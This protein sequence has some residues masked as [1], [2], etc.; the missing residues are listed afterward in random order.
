[1]TRLN[2]ETAVYFRLLFYSELP[3]SPLR[4]PK[5]E[6][7]QTEHVAAAI[8]ELL[9]LIDAVQYRFDERASAA[10]FAAIDPE[11]VR[12]FDAALVAIGCD[13]QRRLLA[14]LQRKLV[15]E[16]SAL[17]PVERVDATARRLARDEAP[18]VRAWFLVDTA[19]LQ[20]RLTGFLE[21]RQQL[22]ELPPYEAPAWDFRERRAPVTSWRSDAGTGG[23]NLFLL[24]AD[25]ALNASI[26]AWLRSCESTTHYHAKNRTRVSN[27]AEVLAAE[28]QRAWGTLATSLVGEPRAGRP[29]PDYFGEYGIFSN[30]QPS[31]ALDR[32]ASDFRWS[33]FRW[34]R[35]D[36]QNVLAF[37]SDDDAV[38]DRFE[39]LADDLGASSL[40]SFRRFD[41][42]EGIAC[43]LWFDERDDDGNAVLVA[44]EHDGCPPWLVLA[45]RDSEWHWWRRTTLQLQ[46]QLWH[47]TFHFGSPELVLGYRD[48]DSAAWRE[49]WSHLSHDSN[50]AVAAVSGLVG[51]NA[52]RERL[53]KVKTL[54]SADDLRYLAGDDGWCYAHDWGSG[55]DEHRAIF[56]A[57]DAAT[58]ARVAGFA[59]Q[60][61]PGS[62]AHHGYW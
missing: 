49:L 55:A 16:F 31:P 21:A 29:V 58:T 52:L 4:K 23:R 46:P 28:K 30:D 17:D 50:V 10:L 6:W 19:M 51:V 13:H 24:R 22:P 34:P 48:I 27:F 12:R 53:V 18:I 25:D 38:A 5:N 43:G 42:L 26:D 57:T 7:S 47:W 60:Q 62:A 33:L 9:A 8:V 59:R 45:A 1:M 40:S 2:D 54:M 61:W 36:D 39:K 15:A 14:L 37:L 20:N 56:F 41:A 44:A 3:T 35:V 11:Q 32:I